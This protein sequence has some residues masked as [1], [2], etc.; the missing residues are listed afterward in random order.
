MKFEKREAKLQKTS[1]W[2]NIYRIQQFFF[3]LFYTLYDRCLKYVFL[4]LAICICSFQTFVR[5]CICCTFIHSCSSRLRTRAPEKWDFAFAFENSQPRKSDFSQI[6]SSFFQTW[7]LNSLS[8]KHTSNF[9]IFDC[10]YNSI[11]WNIL[12]F[13]FSVTVF[14]RNDF[15]QSLA[16]S[17]GNAAIPPQHTW[18]PHTF[19]FPRLSLLLKAVGQR[20]VFIKRVRK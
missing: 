10:N 6:H 12:Q 9:T 1:R 7:K 17:S 20:W 13:C 2:K 4:A 19:L 18:L 16:L 5:Q 8:Q 15:C 11:V 14:Q 3:S